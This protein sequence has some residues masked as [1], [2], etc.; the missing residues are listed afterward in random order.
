MSLEDLKRMG[1]L[2]QEIEEGAAPPRTSVS[3]M[4]FLATTVLSLVGCAGMVVGDGGT[5]TWLGIAAFAGGLFGFIAVN[6]RGVL[7]AP[8]GSP[9]PPETTEPR[10]AAR[11]SDE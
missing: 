8:P 7:A 11:S 9:T 5:L 2:Q 10:A 4:A 6:L 1:L 3:I